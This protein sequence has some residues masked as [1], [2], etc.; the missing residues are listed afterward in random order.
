MDVGRRLLF[1][2][3]F[4]GGIGLVFA[5]RTHINLGSA[6]CQTNNGFIATK[7]FEIYLLVAGKC[8]VRQWKW[9]YQPALPPVT[10]YT[11]PARSGIELGEKL[12]EGIMDVT[13]YWYYM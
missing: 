8:R 2:Y 1:L 10:R 11:R 9:T 5:A 12:D 7:V 3:F 13:L 6:S 4:N